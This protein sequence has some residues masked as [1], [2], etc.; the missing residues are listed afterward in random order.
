MR[1]HSV[2]LFPLLI[3]I[4]FS[5]NS[6]KQIEINSPDTTI[7][8][9][10]QNSAS[11]PTLEI[12]KKGELLTTI[13]LAQFILES[14]TTVTVYTAK[15][16]QRS[17]EDTSWKPV[18]GERSQIRDHYNALTLSLVAESGEKAMNIECRVYDEGIA[19]RYLFDETTFKNRVVREELT[20]FNFDNN[21]ETWI[22]EKWE[23]IDGKMDNN[24]QS[25][26]FKTRLTEMGDNIAEI[27]QVIKR[28]DTSYLAIGE[29][30]LVDYARTRLKKR[31][32]SLIGLQTKIDGNVN[33][34]IAGYITPWRYVMVGDSPG[35]LLENNYLVLNL[36]A[37]NKIEDT[38]WIKPGKVIREVT[39]TTAG[40]MA[41]VDFAERHNI[42]YIEFDAG[43]Y[44]NEYSSESDAT[45]ITVDP[46]RSAGPLDL[47]K[48]IDYA[49]T[50]GV[51]VIL[52][53]NRR[54]LETQLDEILPLY[55]SW[56]VKG[57]KYGFVQTGPQH[58]T[59]W[60]HEAVR[61]A[62]KHELM[63]DVHD[64]YRGSGYTRTYPNLMTMEGIMGD[65]STPTLEND[66]VTIF[67]R[68][69]RGA[70][71]HTIC[72]NAPRVT[73]KMGGKVGQMAKAVM[74]YSPLQFLYWYDRPVGSPVDKGGAG[75]S[76]GII[77]ETED[78]SFFDLLPTVWDD[79]QV[80]E[81]EIGEYGTIVRKS[82]DNWFLGSLTANTERTVNIPLYFLDENT[83]Y[84]ATIY[85]QNEQDLQND[86]VRIE[87]IT[88]TKDS[89]LTKNMVKNSGLAV[90]LR[91]R[92]D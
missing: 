31:E 69:L 79:K 80:L 52:Y 78:L 49:N 36:N 92:Q 91:K 46:G 26:Y 3:L 38:S 33:L 6:E 11:G 22:T 15:E 89:S 74:L 76:V 18:Y 48:I 25:A 28:N 55:K 16:E 9:I 4:L 29:A 35:E 34:E 87:K 19:F 72:Y 88:V 68:M 39:L 40:G 62:A 75:A 41:C 21:Y 57:L 64:E 60:L 1:P 84:E 90:I 61:K 23:N 82:G 12:M 77:K 50:K 65:E 30:A 20:A 56:G 24:S 70:G 58:W 43:W 17:S 53:V 81:G 10:I 66:L 63:V 54:Q 8:A 5:C 83:N 32:D 71:D 86:K 7:S 45:T 67:T 44:G 37:P 13:A 73:E 59:Q 85:S 42:E 27:P 51:G 2:F 14:D 47:H